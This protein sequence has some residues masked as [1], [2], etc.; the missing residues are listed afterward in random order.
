MAHFVRPSGMDDFPSRIRL[1]D[2]YLCKVSTWRHIYIFHSINQ[3]ELWEQRPCNKSVVGA[4]SDSALFL[5][6][7]KIN[8]KKLFCKELRIFDTWMSYDS[9]WRNTSRF[10]VIL[11]VKPKKKKTL[12]ILLS[13]ILESINWKL[14]LDFIVW[15]II[16]HKLSLCKRGAR[17]SK[18][19]NAIYEYLL[20]IIKLLLFI[21]KMNNWLFTSLLSNYLFR[22]VCS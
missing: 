22:N 15:W 10:D 11:C 18:H 4:P 9:H 16:K 19:K 20:Y 8:T 6:Y 17:A 2:G 14:K 7:E 13:L 1:C 5:T 12:Y 21:V 3:P